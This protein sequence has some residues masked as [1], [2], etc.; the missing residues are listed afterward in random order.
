MIR[1]NTAAAPTTTFGERM[2]PANV[3]AAQ[4]ERVDAQVW[5]NIG[6]ETGDD[7]YPV[8]T[9]PFGIA[10]DTMKSLPVPRGKNEK[11]LEFVQR[12]NAL[13]ETIQKTADALAPGE[14]AVIGGVEGGL[15]L[16]LRRREGDVEEAPAPVDGGYFPAFELK[17]AS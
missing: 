12:R 17:L 15:I 11:Y 5:L 1:R 8:V 2:N 4:T 9:L 14:D 10:V 13:L 3:L 7:E 16:Q 6:Y